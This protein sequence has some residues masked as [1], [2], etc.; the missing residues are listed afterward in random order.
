M[1]LAGVYFASWSMA[2]S[3]L[4]L[5]LCIVVGIRWYT[6]HVLKGEI[7]YSRALVVG[8]VISVTTGVIYALYNLA[9]IAWFY[10]SFLSD[11]TR[12]GGVKV[13]A[14][15]IALSNCIRLSVIGSMLSLVAAV[16]LRRT[17]S[18]A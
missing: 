14:P 17:A 7:K 9:S 13:T 4:V 18:S 10:P 6:T 8:V 2:V 16:F 12:A 15:A 1:Y 3:V 5:L 11:M